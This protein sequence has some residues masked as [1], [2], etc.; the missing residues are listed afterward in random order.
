MPGRNIVPLA[1]RPSRARIAAVGLVIAAQLGIAAPVQAEA[2][3]RALGSVA[4]QEAVGA[5]VVSGVLGGVSLPTASAGLPVGAIGSHEPALDAAPG[6]SPA[7]G[8]GALVTVYSDGGTELVSDTTVSVTVSTTGLQ[9]V[10][11]ASGTS[12]SGPGGGRTMILA[13]FN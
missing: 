9:D 1:P 11:G 4:I 6:T 12:A 2:R 10:G 8:D 7:A 3:A 13:Q 5:S